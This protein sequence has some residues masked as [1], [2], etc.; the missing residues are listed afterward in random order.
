MGDLLA[1]GFANQSVIAPLTGLPIAFNALLA[2][3]LAGE[4]LQWKDKIGGA[5]VFG[6]VVMV[7]LATMGPTRTFTVPQLQ[8]FFERPSFVLYGILSAVLITSLFFF[9]WS[10]SPARGRKSN[11]TPRRRALNRFAF[12]AAGGCVGGQQF[13]VKN[14]VTCIGKFHVDAPEKNPWTTN[15]FPYFMPVKIL[16]TTFFRLKALQ[17]SFVH[18]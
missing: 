3:K 18:R 7:A 12:G 5:L 11:D 17:S 1:Y 2:P 15:A 14:M 6:G 10:L 4:V 13:L 8:A 9:A 16:Q